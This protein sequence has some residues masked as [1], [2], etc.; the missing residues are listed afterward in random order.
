MIY[1]MVVEL[2]LRK[3]ILW[4]FKGLLEVLLVCLVVVR[5]LVRMMD[6]V[7]YVIVSLCI[8]NNNEKRY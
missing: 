1:L 5:K 2:L 7:L 6:L 4:F 3:I 8:N